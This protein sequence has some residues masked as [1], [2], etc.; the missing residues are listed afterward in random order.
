M[1]Y[2]NVLCQ[3]TLSELLIARHSC[4]SADR[5]CAAHSQHRGRRAAPWTSCMFSDSVSLSTPTQTRPPHT[6]RPC[7]A[8]QNGSAIAGSQCQ[9][10]HLLR[11]LL[12]V[13]RVFARERRRRC[14][15]TCSGVREAERCR[16]IECQAASLSAITEVDA[17]P[18]IFLTTLSVPAIF[19]AGCEHVIG[20]TLC[21]DSES[22][23]QN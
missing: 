15:N 19:V 4:H 11:T 13:A 9:F 18:G 17:S 22:T 3:M 1:R 14:L 5:G 23:G 6:Q 20:Y 21:T 12:P 8:L 7:T 10:H 16:H 2:W